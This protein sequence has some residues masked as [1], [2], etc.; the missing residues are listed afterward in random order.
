MDSYFLPGLWSNTILF[1]S[2]NCPSSFGWLLCPSDTL[3][4][5][6]DF[7]HL[8]FKF[9]SISLLTAYGFT[10]GSNSGQGTTIPQAVWSKKIF[11]SAEFGKSAQDGRVGRP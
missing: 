6:W 3:P 10:P 1:Y 2:S 5:L 4:S 11:L 9:L 7:H 8:L